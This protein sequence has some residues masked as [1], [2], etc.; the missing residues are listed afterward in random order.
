MF[1]LLYTLKTI[2][3]EG[4]SSFPV[5]FTLL[6]LPLNPPAALN[7]LCAPRVHNSKSLTRRARRSSPLPSVSSTDISLGPFS[8]RRQDVVDGHQV[9]SF[10][11][12][13]PGTARARKLR[14]TTSGSPTSILSC[15]Y[16]AKTDTCRGRP[17]GLSRSA[18]FCSAVPPTQY[19][20]IL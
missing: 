14:R 2:I 10:P 11:S 18:S 15:S 1:W 9:V 12:A 17:I 8:L 5:S 3:S 16:L 20:S 4:S 6:H 13:I 19:P 7:V